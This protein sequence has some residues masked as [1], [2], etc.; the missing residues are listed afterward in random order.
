MQAA[1]TGIRIGVG[2]GGDPT[3]DQLRQARQ[4]GCA[5]IVLANPALPWQ[6]GWAY[7]DLVRLRERIES[8][9]LRLEAIQHTPLDEFDLIRLG[10][11]GQERAL[12]NYQATIRALGRAGIPALCYN[13]RPNRLYRTGEMRGTCRSATGAPTARTSSGRPTT[14]FCARSCRSRSRRG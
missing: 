12:A 5:G 2:L 14:P 8:F 4:M 13:W 3:D 6:G 9:D 10:L 7:D 1:R 11:P